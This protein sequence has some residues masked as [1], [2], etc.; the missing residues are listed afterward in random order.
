MPHMNGLE[1]IKEMQKKHPKVKIVAISGS[2]RGSLATESYLAMAK[3]LG[4]SC[5]LFKITRDN[6]ESA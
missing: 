3:Q 1:L 5:C 6:P 2:G 4:A